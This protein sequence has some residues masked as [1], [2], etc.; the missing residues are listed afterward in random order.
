MDEGFAE[1][2]SFKAAE[3]F[4]FAEEM[5]AIERRMDTYGR[6]FNRFRAVEMSRGINGVFR[7]PPI[8]AGITTD[9]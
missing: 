4:G 7:T 9:G 2:V 5:E 3:Y 6:G 1:W 8:G